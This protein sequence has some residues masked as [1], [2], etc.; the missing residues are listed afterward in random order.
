V[1]ADHNRL[2]RQGDGLPGIGNEVSTFIHQ[3]PCAGNALPAD[4]HQVPAGVQQ[5]P[6]HNNRVPADS[7]AVPPGAD[8]LLR[9]GWTCGDGV[10]GF[11]NQMSPT[12]YAVPGF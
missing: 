2:P 7:D 3:V 1:P 10:S 11:G 4:G 8:D 6:R 5:V 12:G 9:S